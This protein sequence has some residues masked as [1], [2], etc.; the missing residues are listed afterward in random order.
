[1]AVRC[2]TPVDPDGSRPDPA[3]PHR[4]SRRP[5]RRPSTGTPVV[6]ELSTGTRLVGP[7][8]PAGRRLDTGPASAGPGGG[9]TRWTGTA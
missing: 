1:M 9:G 5:G 4:R 3:A 2:A 8:G 6:H 7:V